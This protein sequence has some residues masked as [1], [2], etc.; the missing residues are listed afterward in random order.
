LVGQSVGVLGIKGSGKSN[1][2]AVLMEELLESGAPICVID[3]EGEYF[4]LKDAYPKVTVI[5]RSISCKVDVELNQVDASRMAGLALENGSSIV[6][7]LSGYDSGIREEVVSCFVGAMWK[8]AVRIRKPMIIMIDEARN[9]IPQRKKTAVSDLFIDIVTQGRKRGLS[10][11]MGAQ[12]SA[13]IDKD[14]L[15]QCDIFILHSVTHP[16]D[17]KIYK[18]I[19]PREPK[20]VKNVVSRLKVGQALF[21][22]SGKVLSCD[23]RLR[24]TEHVGF[25]PSLDGNGRQLSLLDL[26]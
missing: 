10:L 25:T 17:M 20:W 6:V 19:I 22:K 1:T 16:A 2:M 4:T 14:T 23:V 11:I 15:T 9:F 3:F 24:K 26:I 12:R 5:G 21:M 7:D 8:L 18:D 13:Q